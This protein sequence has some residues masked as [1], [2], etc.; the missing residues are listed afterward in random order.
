MQCPH[1]RPRRERTRPPPRPLCSRERTRVSAPGRAPCRAGYRATWALAP[2]DARRALP[3]VA[4]GTD[5]HTFTHSHAALDG[6]RIAH[7]TGCRDVRLLHALVYCTETTPRYAH[8]HAYLHCARRSLHASVPQCVV[9]AAVGTVLPHLHDYAV[10]G[11]AAAT[12]RGAAE[13]HGRSLLQQQG[14]LASQELTQ[15]VLCRSKYTMKR[16]RRATIDEHVVAH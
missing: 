12:V 3:L 11:C 2:R 13:L 8:T 5:A 9:V 4:S 10:H 7:S 6:H 1:R 15:R 16:T 14:A